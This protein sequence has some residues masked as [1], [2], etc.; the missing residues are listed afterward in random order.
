MKEN[1][2]LALTI[3]GILAIIIPYVATMLIHTRNKLLVTIGEEA[4]KITSALEETDLG[5]LAKKE[6]AESELNKMFG[7]SFVAKMVGMKI[8]PE[9][10]AKEVD[11]A[12]AILRSM[13][14]KK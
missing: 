2:E 1:L 9:Q 6:A 14:I 11:A 12:V 4:L 3:L 7:G 8:T 13:G 10:L 5:G